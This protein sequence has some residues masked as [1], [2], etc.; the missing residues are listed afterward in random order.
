MKRDLNLF[1]I[2]LLEIEKMPA[3]E[4]WVLNRDSSNLYN[5]DSEEKNILEHL[6]LM[7]DAR[8]ITK[9]VTKGGDGFYELCPCNLTNEGHDFLD[10]VRSSS[11]WEKIKATVLDK[12]ISYSIE[13]IIFLAK[14]FA[15]EQL[16][17]LFNAG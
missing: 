3:G 10:A 14:K 13:S 9:T 16:A 15:K 2:I 17:E 11:V 6:I 1:R 12:G 8:L 5:N 4:D 7:Q